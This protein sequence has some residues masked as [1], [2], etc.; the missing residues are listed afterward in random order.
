MKVIHQEI[1][2]QG[3]RMIHIVVLFFW[4]ILLVFDGIVHNWNNLKLRL[5]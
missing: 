4:V 3:N 5:L 1:I 2:Y